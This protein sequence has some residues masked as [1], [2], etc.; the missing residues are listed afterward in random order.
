MLLTS[1][2]EEQFGLLEG[3]YSDYRERMELATGMEGNC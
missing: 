2:T 1:M 3:R